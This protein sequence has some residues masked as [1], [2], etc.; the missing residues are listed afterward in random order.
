M[1]YSGEHTERGQIRGFRSGVAGSIR[2]RLEREA[3]GAVIFARGP[4]DRWVTPLFTM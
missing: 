2:Y 4:V 1:G 3:I